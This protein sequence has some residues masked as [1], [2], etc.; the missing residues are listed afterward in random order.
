MTLFTSDEK[1]NLKQLLDC[2]VN[3]GEALTLEGLHG[4][5]YG[6]AIIPEPVPP[7]EWLPGI[8][9]KGDIVVENEQEG[10]QLIG[11]LY[12]AYNRFIKLNDNNKLTF[13]FNLDPIKTGDVH[14]IREWA[15]GFFLAIRL[16]LGVWGLDNETDFADEDEDREFDEQMEENAACSAVIMSVA[17]PERIPE[18]FNSAES[19][20]DPAARD[21]S[22][23]ENRFIDMLPD[24]VANLQSYANRLRDGLRA[25]RAEKS[26]RP[27]LRTTDKI[28]RND[29]CPCGSGKKY[30]KCCGK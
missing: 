11:S 10:L 12:A 17:F 14:R 13:P 30:K 1:T 2:A 19:P 25:L 15:Y 5:L 28:G 22:G 6:L 3:K 27:G 18:L 29:P 26:P 4:Y 16:R 9:N 8:L 23:D 20:L 24:A 21:H 7:S